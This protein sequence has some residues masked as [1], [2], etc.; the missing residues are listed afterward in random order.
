MVIPGAYVC[1]HARMCVC[2]RVHVHACD[3]IE[4]ENYLIVV[5]PFRYIE[6]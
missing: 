1:V 2:L 3:R 5:N 6:E 4:S